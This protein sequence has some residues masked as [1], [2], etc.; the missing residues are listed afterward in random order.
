MAVTC[1]EVNPLGFLSRIL[2]PE[3][4][5]GHGK[6]R[7][8]FEGWYFKLVSADQSQRWA[9]IP[10]L[11]L[12]EDGTAEAFVQVLDGVGSRTWYVPFA[13]DAFQAST[14]RLDVRVGHCHFSS[15][16]L[17]VGG[18]GLPLE[19]RVRFGPLTPWPV[20]LRSP[21]VMDWYGYVPFMECYHGVVSLHH[22][23]AGALRV[24]GKDVSFDGGVGFAE[25]DWG[26]AFPVGYVWMQTNQFPGSTTSLVA[27]IALIPWLLGSFRGFIV[28]LWH[29]GRLHRFATY[30]GAKTERLIIDDAHVDWTM[31]DRHHRLELRAARRRGGILHAP[32]RT[33]MHRRVEETLDAR[34][35]VRL[36]ERSGRAVFEGEGACAGLEVHGDLA[37]LLATT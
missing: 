33:Q 16:G 9:V 30:T 31:A 23:L 20:T 14:E 35:H 3:A 29:D 7:R 37:R 10:G 1:A 22:S 8:F 36:T 27:S 34:V 2:H 4:F 24:E 21:G 15:E 6:T 18:E 13:P 28:G 11:F 5:H 32:V 25:K 12:G 26:A 17:V 19:G